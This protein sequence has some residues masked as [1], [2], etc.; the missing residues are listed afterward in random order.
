MSPGDANESERAADL[1]RRL[2]HLIA[3]LPQ[4]DRRELAYVI[5][6]LRALDSLPPEQLH[7]TINVLRWFHAIGVNKQRIFLDAYDDVSA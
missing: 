3:Q 7:A 5:R 1:K 2:E 4:S 6:T